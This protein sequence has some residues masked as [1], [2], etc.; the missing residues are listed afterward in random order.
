MPQTVNLRRQ[1]PVV[2][3]QYPNFLMETRFASAETDFICYLRR[4]GCSQR[5]GRESAEIAFN[6]SR[7]Q[8]LHMT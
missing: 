3:V 6:Q 1:S 7:K 4:Y 2:N 5:G 8:A